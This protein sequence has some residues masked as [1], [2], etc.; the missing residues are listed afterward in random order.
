MNILRDLFPDVEKSRVVDIHTRRRPITDINGNRLYGTKPYD[1]DPA[2]P[3]H[4]AHCKV[5]V[6]TSQGKWVMLC[7]KQAKDWFTAVYGKLSQQGQEYEIGDLK[8][9]VFY[10]DHMEYIGMHA[11][12]ERLEETRKILRILQKL[13]EVA[14]KEK[15]IK[16]R[17][18]T[19]R[20]K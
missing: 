4:H 3:K 11:S 13:S 7:G 5:Q 2:L 15:W 14:V 17:L 12:P 1:F 20:L 18:E 10:M 19:L 6:E 8:R 16:D 9:R